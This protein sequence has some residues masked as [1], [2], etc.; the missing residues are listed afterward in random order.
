MYPVE[1]LESLRLELETC[2]PA[3]AEGTCP[4]LPKYLMRHHRRLSSVRL[5]EEEE[6]YIVEIGVAC[7]CSSCCI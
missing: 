1:A 7:A 5:V 6:E 3:Q 2:G 4:F